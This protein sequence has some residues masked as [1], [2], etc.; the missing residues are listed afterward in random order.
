MLSVSNY[1][2]RS[3]EHCALDAA[4]AI[5]G[6]L[7]M[8]Q[9]LNFRRSMRLWQP[10]LTFGL[11]EDILLG[12][13]ARHIKRRLSAEQFLALL[14]TTHI[15]ALDDQAIVTY[16]GFEDLVHYYSEMSA[17]GDREAEFGLFDDG[18][19]AAPVGDG[20]RDWGRI[21]NV[22]VPFAAVHALDD[23]LTAWRTV[24]TADPQS[25]ADSGSGNVIV[26]LTESG[27]HVGWPLGNNPAENQWLWMS[28][29]AGS[30]A[31]AVDTARRRRAE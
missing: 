7:D 29:L 31:K 27:G 14:R 10:M 23:P 22:S 9:M 21:A 5:S 16:N 30:F 6:G 26:V 3:G 13:F 17:M 25:L 2:A 24:G 8:R 1:V 12:K 11:R 28:N 15:S 4:I 18:G 19:A 20:R